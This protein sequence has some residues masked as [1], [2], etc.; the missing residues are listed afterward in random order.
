MRFR[1]VRPTADK[2]R[3]TPPRPRRIRNR[4]TRTPAALGTTL[5]AIC[6]V[7]IALGASPAYAQPP[8]PG[9]PSVIDGPTSTIVR[10]AGL[11][12]SVARDGTGGLVYLKTVGGVAHVFV[13]RLA[14]GS[15]GA[16]F[17]VDQGMGRASSEPL[18]AAGTGGLLIVAFINSGQLYVVQGNSAG[19]FGAPQPLV[20]AAQNP[21]IS[22][23]Y[24]GKAYLAFTVPDGK[25][26]D[27]R[28][29][30]YYNGRWA[31]ESPPLNQSPADDA[32]TGTGRPAVAAAGDGIA[33]VVWGEQGHIYSRRVWGTAAS[34][35][36]E[37]ADA[38]P[39]GCTETSADEPLVGAGGDS[40]YAP[41]AFHEGVTCGG[42]QQ[43]RV[44]VNRLQGSRFDGI[45]A[46]DGLSAASGEGAGD[47]QIAV[48]E[49]GR[50]WVTSAGTTSD[51]VFAAGLGS[52]GA[53]NG[54]VLQVNSLT[55]SAAPDQVP[56][57]AGVNANFIAWQQ[58]PGSTPGGEI[59]IR[60]APDGSTLGPETVI[61]SPDQGPTDAADG[62]AA[63]GDTSG[64]GVVAWLQGSP[65]ATQ[66]MVGQLYQPPGGFSPAKTFAYSTSSQPVLA[67]ARPSGWGP[68]EY[69]LSVDGV[70]V[71]QGSSTTAGVPAP[72]ADGPHGWRVTATNP[73]GQQRRDSA[74]TI[75]VDTVAP[76][77]MV[78]LPHRA[79][80]RST[81]QARIRYADLPPAGEPAADASG[82]ATVV[83]RW[84]D[85]SVTR[86]PLRHH[87]LKHR[88]R[89]PGRYQVLLRVADR[90]GNVTRVVTVIRILK[91]KHS[92]KRG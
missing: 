39:S 54:T 50:G 26:H 82:V 85:G 75:F 21:A 32:G 18:I 14:G 11:K 37:Q 34:E 6:V 56:A 7:T 90:A 59:R 73:A 60:F 48:T 19:Q 4:S 58:D 63:A 17:Q 44:L 80:A 71:A 53:P 28:T 40:S 13:S 68:M 78:T 45:T 27:V 88:Y 43:S 62:L 20:G 8:V 81:I 91:P 30:Y 52:N 89:R 47:P 22:I 69:A 92:R 24:F 35:V 38:P 3:G 29:A 33:I 10:P 77:A 49:Y 46:A 9:P 84:G 2:Q 15:F 86:V 64:D 57:A 79:R 83:V 36:D 16:P 61:S 12:V 5:A 41:V 25:G 31:L 66:L 51:N 72:L 1:L 76:S 67:W 55:E 65:G 74:A 23:T 87:A 42:H 70:Q